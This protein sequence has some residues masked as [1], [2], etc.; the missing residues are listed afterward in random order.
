MK[1]MKLKCKPAHTSSDPSHQLREI[2]RCTV[3]DKKDV[4][5]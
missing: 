2:K 3:I 1:K 4:P 5:M